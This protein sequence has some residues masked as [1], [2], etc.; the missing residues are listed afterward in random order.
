MIKE[1]LKNNL[2]KQSPKSWLNVRKAFPLTGEKAVNTLCS[3]LPPTGT[4]KFTIDG[5]A[6]LFTLSAFQML[7]FFQDSGED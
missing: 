3:L 4:T 2:K 7:S 6:V 5:K 1:L